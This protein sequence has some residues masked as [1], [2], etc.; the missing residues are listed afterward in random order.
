MIRMR[1]EGKVEDIKP[2]KTKSKKILNKS[3]IDKLP[4]PDKVKA[5]LD[6]P[7]RIKTPPFSPVK[8]KTS[9]PVSKSALDINSTPKV[10][11]NI[12]LIYVHIYKNKIK[13]KTVLILRIVIIF[14]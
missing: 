4:S 7:K 1:P 11:L 3:E 12:N 10:N 14:L 13:F 2:A 5:S 9:S 6:S 8:T